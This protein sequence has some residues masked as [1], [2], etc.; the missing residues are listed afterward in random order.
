MLDPTYSESDYRAPHSPQPQSAYPNHATI[1]SLPHIHTMPSDSEVASTILAE[2]RDLRFH[3]FKA[4]D[5]VT[6]GLSIRKRF[7]SSHRA[8]RGKGLVISIE[9]LGGHKLFACSVGEGADVSMDSWLC[10]DGMIRVVART[11]HS[12][13]YLE[14]GMMAIGKSQVDLGIPFPQYRVNGGAFPIWLHN[15]P[16]FPIGVIAVYGGSSQEDHALVV[17]TLRDFF[18]KLANPKSSD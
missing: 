8:A 10:V 11:G 9:S 12:T 1:A 2:E 18:N 7:R 17:N 5:A 15:V 16:T 14:K 4:D 6:I 3:S 13:W